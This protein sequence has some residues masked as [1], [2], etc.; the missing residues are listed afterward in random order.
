MNLFKMA[1]R[2][3]WR[4]QRRTIVTVAAMTLALLVMILYSALMDGYLRDMERSVLDLEVGDVQVFAND[5]RDNPSLY[6]RIE[7]PE[8]LLEPLSEAG[9]R[10]SGRLLAYGMA[11]AGESSAGVS[12]RGI[13]VARD[14]HVS[15]VHEQLTAGTWLDPADP[16]GVVLGR[17]LARTLAVAPQD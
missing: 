14:A 10:A 15:L 13:D 5:Y 9:F 3:V 4:H 16:S 2:N 6:T 17:R 7:N 11:A 1:W 8:E 12:F